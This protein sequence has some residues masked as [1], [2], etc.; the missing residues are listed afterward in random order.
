[1][2]KTMFIVAMLFAT[3]IQAQLRIIRHQDEMTDKVYYYPSDQFVVKS[4]DGESG[5]FV[6]LSLKEEKSRITHSGIIV[7]SVNI[8]SCFENDNLIVLFDNGEKSTMLSWNKFNCEGNSY[9]YIPAKD[10]ELFKTQ[11]IKKVRF[12]N[13]RS[14]ESLTGEVE[15]TEYFITLFKL[16]AENKFEKE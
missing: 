11:K 13:G 9:F 12:E 5:F 10:L 1:M 15:N 6:M 14:H 4:E 2:K 16:M 3:Q 7:Q 8:G